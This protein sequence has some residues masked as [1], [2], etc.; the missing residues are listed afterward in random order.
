MVQFQF[1]K[2]RIVSNFV[3]RVVAVIGKLQFSVL[4]SKS[5]NTE[6]KYSELHF[7]ILY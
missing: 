2:N 1:L 3:L 5:H 4:I 6:K 7:C